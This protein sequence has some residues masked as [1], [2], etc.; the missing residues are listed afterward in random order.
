[1]FGGRPGS[2]LHPHC[3]AR[4]YNCVLLNC[5]GCRK[6]SKRVMQ[7]LDSMGRDELIA[8]VRRLH[9]A[10]R[11]PKMQMAKPFMDLELT[12]PQLRA[13]F[14]LT[15]SEP[16][17]MSPLAQDLG[18]T[19]SACTHLVDNLVRAGFVSRSDDQYDRRVVR[20]SLT[21]KGQALAE[22]LRQASPFERAE[23]LDRLTAEE[24]RAIVQAMSIFHRVVGEMQV[25]EK[26]GVQ[27]GA[28]KVD[29]L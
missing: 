20:C 8:E 9:A 7:D 13:V 12:I 16:V 29:G 17:S 14:L 26:E 2:A 22:R 19:L 3:C 11:S 18:I 1:L 6:L 23:F 5:C 24:L 10:V 21:E 15:E 27:T 25:E 28:S 4:A